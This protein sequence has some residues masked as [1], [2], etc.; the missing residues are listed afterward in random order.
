M[1]FPG[2]KTSLFVPRP[3]LTPGGAHERGAAAPGD[4]TLPGTAEGP[5]L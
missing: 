4:A 2:W 3:N 1:F 5:S